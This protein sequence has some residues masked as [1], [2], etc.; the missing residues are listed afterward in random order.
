RAPHPDDPRPD[1]DRGDPAL[2]GPAAAPGAGGP[3]GAISERVGPRPLSHRSAAGWHVVR[4]RPLGT[5]PLGRPV[6]RAAVNRLQLRQ[7]GVLD[8]TSR[9]APPARHA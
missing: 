7:R 9:R 8:G 3:R 4:A 6:L 2:A 5:P 1:P